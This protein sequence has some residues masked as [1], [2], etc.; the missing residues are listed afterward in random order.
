RLSENALAMAA[1][2]RALALDPGNIDA[3]LS[4][5]ELLL[6]SGQSTLSLED[7]RTAVAGRPYDFRGRQG[8]A[9]AELRTALGYGSQPLP[10]ESGTVVDNGSAVPALQQ[11]DSKDTTEALEALRAAAA[12]GRGKGE[13]DPG[14]EVPISMLMTLY[15]SP[16]RQ[17]IAGF[18][19][20]P[21]ADDF[22]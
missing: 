8:L 17:T 18:S 22:A 10:V 5:A 13:L 11:L 14:M 16:K 9:I 6:V 3:H 2:D 4:R 21:A 7:F 1:L 15:F 12:I 20:R 19:R